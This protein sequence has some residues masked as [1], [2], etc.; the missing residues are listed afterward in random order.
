MDVEVEKIADSPNI[1]YEFVPEIVNHYDQLRAEF[2]NGEDEME[3]EIENIFRDDMKF[4][5]H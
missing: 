2:N 4:L 3:V 1:S 5:Y